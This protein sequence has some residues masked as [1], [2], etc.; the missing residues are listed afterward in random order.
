MRSDPLKHLTF[1]IGIQLKIYSMDLKFPGGA[2]FA[3]FFT[4]DD[5]TSKIMRTSFCELFLLTLIACSSS[6]NKNIATQD[7]TMIADTTAA[8]SKFVEDVAQE[9]EFVD[10]DTTLEGRYAAWK[11]RIDMMKDTLY[12]VSM[13]NKQYEASSDATWFFDAEMNAVYFSV[14]WSM[15]GTGG[16]TELIAME[17]TV[18]CSTVEENST[19]EKWCRSTG[20]V[21][22]T[23]D[24]NSGE[25]TKTDLEYDYG[26]Q[27]SE[28]LRDELTTLSAFLRDA[29]VVEEED[30]WLKLRIEKVVN[31]G[32]DFTEYGEVRVPRKVYEE[33][34]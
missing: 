3:D 12:E 22:T 21:R 23:M 4:F 31:Y 24:D 33:L 19:N 9:K 8:V 25:E 30:G 20:G 13:T 11:D 27:Q 7:S 5:L 16:F 2:E 1:I 32:E 15:E 28:R 14:S 29:K 34:R 18:F 26:N 6:E 17:S 10:G